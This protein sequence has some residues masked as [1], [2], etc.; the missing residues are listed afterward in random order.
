MRIGLVFL[1]VIAI[2]MTSFSM[3]E[4]FFPSTNELFGQA[5]PS[6]SSTL[7]RQA[8]EV[9]EVD[10]GQQ[11]IFR[12]ISAEDYIAFSAY[13]G[14]LDCTAE[15]VAIEDG[16]LT[17]D[18]T[19][20]GGK[21]IFAYDDQEGVATLFYPNGTREEDAAH[22]GQGKGEA[23]PDYLRNFGVG[24]PSMG[25]VVDR[26][27]T[28]KKEP[29]FLQFHYADVSEAEYD[30]FSRYLKACGCT[31]ADF[32]VASG[33]A[34]AELKQG[35]VSF[36]FE[37]DSNTHVATIEYPAFS[38]VEDGPFEEADRVGLLPPADEAFGVLL[39]R[40]ALATGLKSEELVQTE[41]G[42][43]ET[44][45]NFTEEEYA[46]FSVYLQERGCSVIDYGTD[47]KGVLT[48][49]LEKSGVPFSLIYDRIRNT[50]VMRY[51]LGSRPEPT[52]TP[53]P[54]LIPTSTPK[55]QAKER[56]TTFYSESDCWRTAEVYFKGM[57]WKN[58][59]S[60]TIH[61]H[62]SSL[63]DGAYTFLIDYSAQNGFG[64]YN[65]STGMVVVD[66]TTGQV[67][68]AWTN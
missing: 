20:D 25:P 52:P 13:L 34:A 28:T 19:M 2:M 42:L 50:A 32:S 14:K 41:E 21:F 35:N 30:D 4:G 62:T 64:G 58:P 66:V 3:A 33:V 40:I 39:P 53:E 26:E 29:G 57:S 47:A 5:M 48:I 67:T 18:I 10:G 17:A 45:Q 54:T 7:N 1:L 56:T 31:L 8:D 49:D 23:L 51:A 38:F 55:P 15:N 22:E 68:M 46:R 36:H 44:Y 27:P 60:L 11:V 6:L 37:Y 61:G 63:S 24:L 16:V 65:R 43:E 59:D 9:K 12:N